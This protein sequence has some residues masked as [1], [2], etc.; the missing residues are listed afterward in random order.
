[1][2]QFEFP[3]PYVARNPSYIQRCL[4]CF[5]R[6]PLGGNRR[7][8]AKHLIQ[9]MGKR[10]CELDILDGRSWGSELTSRIIS[11]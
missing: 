11:N 6:M 1:M 2:K 5:Q 7:E 3:S 9:L 4:I 10:A 8:N